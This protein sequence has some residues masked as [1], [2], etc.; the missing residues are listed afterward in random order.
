M[1][2]F[3]KTIVNDAAF[4]TILLYILCMYIHILESS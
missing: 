2:E 3:M 1:L 4:H